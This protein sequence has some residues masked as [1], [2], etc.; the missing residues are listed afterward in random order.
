MVKAG[1]GDAC[2]QPDIDLINRTIQGDREAFASL[3]LSY[4]EM[5]LGWARSIVQDSHL[6]EDVVQE[7]FLRLERKIIDLKDPLRFHPWLR[8]MVRR[9]AM[10]QI[11]GSQNRLSF[12]GGMLD[13]APLNNETLIP[14]SSVNPQEEFLRKETEDEV[15]ADTA[16]LLSSQAWSV[17][18]AFAVKEYTP[19]EIA[20]HY[21]MTKSNVYNI[22]S[23]ARNKAIDERF[24]LETNR[25]LTE[26][27]H[28]GLGMKKELTDPTFSSPYSHLS[29]GIY[30]SLRYAANSELTLT[31][32]MGIS[33][34][35]FRLNVATGCHWRGISTYDWSYAAYHAM[36]RLGWQVKCFGRPGRPMVTPEQQVQIIQILHES[37]DKGIPAILWNLSINEFG[38][39]YGYDDHARTILYKGFG[40][41]AKTYSYDQLGRTQEG[42]GL[43]VAAI[44]RRVSAPAALPAVIASIINHAR[45]KEP[46][47][48]GFAYGLDGYLLWIASVQKGDLDLMGHAYQVAI[49]SESR[50]HA[51][52]FLGQ[53]SQ[54]AQTKELSMKL[55][56][57]ASKYRQVQ[58]FI[59]RLYPSFPFGYGGSHAGSLAQI[60]KGLQ[61]V[62]DAEIEGV[63]SLERIINKENV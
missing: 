50:Y 12:Y 33:G 16:T 4:R 38:F 31:E 23:R 56:D 36:E 26:R 47:I 1:Q 28:C 24:H 61:A 6:A 3:V 34:E 10:N 41:Q 46:S 17:M 63:A 43:F 58:E 40:Q 62:Y 29:L 30:E 8:Q 2:I 13:G 27:H 57:A 18:E 54:K 55:E 52:Q 37:I 49:L 7:V 14:S 44:G 20:S 42:P 53:L 39:V 51:Y 59:Q 9:Q 45:G 11:R 25:Y 19:E 21:Q 32:I 15:L 48:P 5:A 22:L 35:A 60:G